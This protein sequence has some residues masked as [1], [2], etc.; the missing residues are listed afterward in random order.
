M[1]KSL[2][3]LAVITATSGAMAQSSVQL[4]GR[5]DV[6]FNTTTSKIDGV[7]QYDALTSG[8]NALRHPGSQQGINSS[9][10]N[11][12]FWGI[13]GTE[14]LGGGLKAMFMLQSNFNTDTGAA[15]A[16]MFDREAWLGLSGGF[17]TIKL[18][19]NYTAYDTVFGATNHNFNSNINVSTAVFNVGIDNY[20]L[21]NSNS[22]RYEAPTINGFN[23]AVSYG[24]GENKTAT[25]SATDTLSLAVWYSNGPILAAFGHQSEERRDAITGVNT[26]DRDHTLLGGG[27]DFGAFR[28]VGSVQRT[29]EG[30][31]KD[32]DFQIGVNV[33]L[34]NFAV[35]FG[36]ADGRTKAGGVTR[37][38]DGYA[39]VGT[40]NLS[41]RTTAYVGYE[42]SEVEGT[43]PTVSTTKTSNFAVGLRHTF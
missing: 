9:Q 27:Y 38:S 37:N 28:L 35:A 4:F 20:T 16:N 21:R 3:A 39:L 22:I 34:G 18:G 17:G 23:A 24:F 19:R 26:P 31:R 29:K 36:Y 8:P 6:G 30:P 42:R 7:K 5:L 2:I 41:K 32:R 33:P 10:L 13:R 43:A 15:A 25:E 14:D 40:Y 1:K 12:Q 11:T